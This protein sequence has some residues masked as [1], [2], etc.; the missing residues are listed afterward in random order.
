MG[1]LGGG[2]GLAAAPDARAIRQLHQVVEHARDEFG[3][4][5]PRYTATLQRYGAAVQAAADAT[6][7]WEPAPD[8]TDAEPSG[9]GGVICYSV[10]RQAAPLLAAHFL[11]YS[12]WAVGECPRIASRLVGAPAI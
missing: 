9:P 11:H 4:D 10:Q 7:S 2:G 3:P 5:D 12:A 1:L 6:A 8:E